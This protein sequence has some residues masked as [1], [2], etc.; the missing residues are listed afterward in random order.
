MIYFAKSASYE[1]AGE[2][3][4][5]STYI[6]APEVLRTSLRSLPPG[7]QRTLPKNRDNDG[8]RAAVAVPTR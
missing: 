1:W 6:E 7:L 2:D 4:H 5:Q 8:W 3:Q